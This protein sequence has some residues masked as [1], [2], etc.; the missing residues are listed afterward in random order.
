[1]HSAL[2]VGHF[3]LRPASVTAA[4]A[5]QANGLTLAESVL[6]SGQRVTTAAELLGK[7][8]APTNTAAYQRLWEMF[9]RLCGSAQ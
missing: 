7:G 3:R 6:G 4:R 9:E 2:A 5:W 1:M 8:L